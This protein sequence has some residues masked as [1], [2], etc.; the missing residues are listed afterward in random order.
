MRG[1]RIGFL[2][3]TATASTEGSR[4]VV[5]SAWA[6]LAA[7]CLH[8]LAGADHLAALTPLTI[9]RSTAKASLLGALWGFGH[10][11]GQL[12]LGLLMVVLKDRFERLVPTL[13]KWGGT[14][15]GLTLL[16]IGA[17]GIWECISDARR[18]GSTPEGDLHVAEANLG[19]IQQKDDRSFL[20]Y[21]TGIVYGLQPDALFVIIP[22]LALPSKLAAVAYILLFVFGTVAAMGGYTAV[23]GATSDAIRRT[24]SGL[25]TSLSGL[26]SG[27]A[28]VV[29]CCILLSGWGVALPLTAAA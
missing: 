11:T 13:S 18:R 24:N 7:G 27:V 23:I 3:I 2:S 8:T 19:D 15:V 5:R 10:S 20:L 28:I 16:A 9:G 1:Q 14:T 26:A 25:T 12:L 4:T 21:V 6:G 17:L 29:G 22:A